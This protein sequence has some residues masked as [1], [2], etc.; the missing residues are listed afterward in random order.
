M[1]SQIDTLFRWATPATPGCV[2]AVSQNGQVILNRAYGSAD[3]ERTVPLTPDAIFDMGSLRKQFIAAA[4]LLLVEEG[5]LSLNDDLHKYFP[6]LPTYDH[7]ITLDHLLTHT[8]GVRDW[9]GL[10]PLTG[11]QADILTLI[12]R[13]RNLNFIPG[14]EWAY[15]NS[16]Y[17]LLKELVERAS[18]LP[19]SEFARQRLFD[20]LGMTNTAYHEDL[21]DV[22]ENRALAYAKDSNSWKQD[23]L[24]GDDRG[25]GALFSTARDLLI[26]NDALTAARLGPFVTAKLQEPARLNNGRTLSY[27]RGL[28]IEPYRKGKVI[29]HSG[30]AA[31]YHSWLGRLPND[32]LSIAVL[33]N[34]DAVGASTIARRIAEV[35]LP[36]VNPDSTQTSAPTTTVPTG[37]LNGKAG[38]FLDERTGEPLRLLSDNGR[39]S[40]P[41][42]PPLVPVSS[43]H[44]RNPR[45][46][47]FFR[48]QDEFELH[49]LSQN[50]LELISMEGQKTSYRRAQPT[51]LTAA[52]LQMLAGRYENNEVGS[53][54]RLVS[55]DGSLILRLE[56]NP[57]TGISLLPVARDLY[58]AG[59][60][61][62]RFQRDSAGKVVGFS[63]S[64]P[65]V[66][67][68][69]FTRSDRPE[70][71]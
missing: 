63:Y 68:L 27:A 49:F 29:W 11:G 21:R 54:L 39:L 30:A 2:I 55:A 23:M 16:G 70:G 52:D 18:S 57:D 19:F 32:K 66:R 34:S 20:P 17:V 46:D 24:L 14:N 10:Q 58:Q 61:T 60:M 25:G 65:T 56:F 67:N 44:F 69:Q 50:Q 43:D 4:V 9:T 3:L 36:A 31:G 22:I 42:G 12:L 28:I 37:D 15:S 48:S 40:I 6:E 53:V 5:R 47:L 26:W 33:C 45:G 59:G 8:S 35:F 62:V 64:N 38:L 71:Q 1:P 13:Q 7:T 51:T 41:G